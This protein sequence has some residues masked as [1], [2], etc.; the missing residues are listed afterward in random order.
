MR[1]KFTKDYD[2]TFE[3]GAMQFFPK[4]TEMTVKRIVG[5]AAIAA[6]KGE[7]V[8]AA[9]GDTDPDAE[10]PAEIIHDVQIHDVPV[11][12]APAA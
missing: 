2:H 6:G 12:K 1:I 8:G 3:S 5:D 7:E 10:V 11:V 4:G 9:A